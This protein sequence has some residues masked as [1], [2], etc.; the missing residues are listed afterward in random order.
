MAVQG[1]LTRYEALRV[2]RRIGVNIGRGRTRL[3]AADFARDIFT[4]MAA[5]SLLTGHR[6]AFEDAWCAEGARRE[7]KAACDRLIDGHSTLRAAS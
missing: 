4:D 1:P 3:D 6:W 7:S 2:A 5:D